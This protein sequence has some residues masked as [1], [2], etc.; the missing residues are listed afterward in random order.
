MSQFSPSEED[1]AVIEAE[2]FNKQDAE[3]NRSVS[4]QFKL[5]PSRGGVG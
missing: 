5:R 2:E 4:K 1:K 3:W